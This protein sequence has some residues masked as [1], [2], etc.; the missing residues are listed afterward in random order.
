MR[1]RVRFWTQNQSFQC[2]LFFCKLNFMRVGT[3]VFSKRLSEPACSSQFHSTSSWSSPPVRNA[4]RWRTFRF[5]TSYFC[6]WRDFVNQLVSFCSSIYIED[7]PNSHDECNEFADPT[8][9]LKTIIINHFAFRETLCPVLLHHLIFVLYWSLY[10][11]TSRIHSAP[12]LRFSH[13]LF[14]PIFSWYITMP[15]IFL[16]P[17]DAVD[18]WKPGV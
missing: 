16:I 11:C 6:L 3:V 4:T 18:R 10:F 5:F 13:I 1:W 7:S 12:F 9:V 2:Y 15:N 17:D 14:T 8:F